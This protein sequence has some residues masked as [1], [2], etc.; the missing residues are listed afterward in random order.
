MRLID[1]QSW[2]RRKHF[3]IYNAF[4]YPHINL[5]APVEIA[6][7]HA[8]VKQRSLS[9]NITLVY[10][11]ARAANAIPEFRY[12][13]R[14]GQVVEHDVVHPSSTIMTESDL[15]SFCTIPYVADYA[16]FAAQ[17]AAIIEQIQQPRLEDEPGQDD[18]LFMTSLPWVSFTALQ[19]PIHM[20]P[21][22]SV[23]RIS[24]G[25]FYAEGSGLKL[26]LSVQVHHA[27]M[28]GV[29]IGRYFTQVQAYLDQPEHLLEFA[30]PM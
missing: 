4:D 1:V 3:E 20:H 7:F 23:P 11:F 10:L 5:C 28:D 30:E 19:H 16:T 21:V 27:L 17:A 9:L 25:K 2:P 29:H 6:A 18:L 13:I 15:F 26:P 14:A 12:R 8:F 22:D 24:W